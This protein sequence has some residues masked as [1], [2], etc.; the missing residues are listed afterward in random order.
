MQIAFGPLFGFEIE[1]GTQRG[2]C[3]NGKL[4]GQKAE[5]ALPLA[6]IVGVLQR[7]VNG[8]SDQICL[9]DRI[10]LQRPTPNHGASRL[11]ENLGDRA[12]S[13]INLTEMNSWS[14]RFGGR[15]A[16]Q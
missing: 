4:S 14:R 13:I 11:F 10:A 1:V 15:G 2:Q 16:C 12:S 3:G 9:S 8:L 5:A 6:E 7:K